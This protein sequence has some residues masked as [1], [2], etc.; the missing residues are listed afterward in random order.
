[1]SLPAGMVRKNFAEE[2]IFE[3]ILQ[4]KFICIG[5]KVQGGFRNELLAVR[6]GLMGVMVSPWE[7]P[8]MWLQ[9]NQV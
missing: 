4:G 6:R 3:L 5:R 7:K 1:M 8:G 2:M 9:G